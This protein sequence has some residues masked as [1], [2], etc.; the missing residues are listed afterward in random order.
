MKYFI[1]IQILIIILF[2][3]CF[4]SNTPVDESACTT[5]QV[6][7][8]DKIHSRGGRINEVCVCSNGVWYVFHEGGLTE[9]IS[10]TELYEKINVGDTIE[11]TY[12][13][14]FRIYGGWYNLV[15]DA[16]D[17]SNSYVDFDLFNSERQSGQI[18][19]NVFFVIIEIIYLLIAGFVLF[20]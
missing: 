2:L 11:I 1:F 16:K 14:R 20:I 6:V 17:D 18:V 13:E 10:M 8:E 12:T 4:F 9:E 5:V 15:V 19:F 3:G 7:V